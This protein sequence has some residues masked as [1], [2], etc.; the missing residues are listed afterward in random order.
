MARKTTQ[1]PLVM[2]GGG[3]A[4]RRLFMIVVGMV[5]FALILRDPV[6]AAQAVERV[7]TGAGAVLDALTRFAAA[8][9]E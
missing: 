6:G 5:L 1:M 4:G 8:L 3:G 2:G 9:A 7:G